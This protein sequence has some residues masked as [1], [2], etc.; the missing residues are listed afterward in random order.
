MSE[1]AKIQQNILDFIRRN[2]GLHL[3]KLAELNNLKITE[4]EAHLLYLES[5]GKIRKFNEDGITKYYLC[6]K[7]KKNRSQRISDIRNEIY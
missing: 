5:K 3:S 2:P 1:F 7:K 6:E 4:I